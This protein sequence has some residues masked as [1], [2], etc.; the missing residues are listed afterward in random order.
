MDKELIKQAELF[1]TNKHRFKFRKDG[2]TPYIE[3][4]REVVSKLIDW[5]YRSYF[6]KN[7]SNIFHDLD[8]IICA[9]WLHDT[10]EKTDTK[11]DEIAEKFGYCITCMVNQISFKE[12]EE[13]EEQYYDRNKN[14]IVKFADHICNTIYFRNNGLVNFKSYFEKGKVI[15]DNFSKYN[16]CREDLRMINNWIDRE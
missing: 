4:P 1:A 9:G 13:S 12:N 14:N 3:H 7:E 11:L 8:Y 2:F 5:N 16:F 15:I 6:I 10:I